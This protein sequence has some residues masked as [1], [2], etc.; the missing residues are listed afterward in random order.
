MSANERSTDSFT[1][2]GGVP[3]LSRPILSPSLSLS[4]WD[5]P[6]LDGAS[7]VRPPGLVVLPTKRHPDKKVPVVKTT[8]LAEIFWLPFAVMN[9]RQQ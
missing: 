5:S 4:V 8:E 9:V 6:A 1:I 7:P 3:V 2:L